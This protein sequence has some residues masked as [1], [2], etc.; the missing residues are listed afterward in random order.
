M[1]TIEPDP[2]ELGSDTTTNPH[3]LDG[4]GGGIPPINT[5]AI[6]FKYASGSR[7]LDG[8]VIKRGIGRGGFGEVYFATSDAGK[9]VALKRIERNLDVELRG[10]SQCL[11]LKH[12]NLIDLYDIRYDDAGDAWV[13]MEYVAGPSL[14]DTIDR[15]PNGLPLDQVQ[16]WF[17][18][19]A[20][21][22]GYLHD[23]GIVHRDLKPANIFQDSSYVKIGDYGLSKFISVSRRS[24]QTESVGTVHYMAPEIGKGVYGKEIDLYALG[25]VLFEM[26]TG[27]TPFDGESSQEI[28]MKHLTADPDLSAVPQPYRFVIERA[29]QK[30]AANRFHSA[31]E[32]VAALAG[33]GS[34][35]DSRERP[36]WRSAAHPVGAGHLY[37]SPSPEPLAPSPPLSDEP[38]ARAVRDMFANIHQWWM[39]GP[40]NTPLKVALLL[41][42]AIL[43]LFSSKLILP[44]AI[45]L[46]SMYI[47]YLGIRLLV[48]SAGRNT[49]AATVPPMPVR[50]PPMPATSQP[51][52]AQPVYAQ[53]VP[54]SPGW[55]PLSWEQQGRQFLCQKSPAEHAA[56][57]S[58]SMLFAA[59]VAG[60]LTIVM[61]AIG[62]ESLV[63][64]ADWRVGPAWFW[65]MTTL[66]TWLVLVAGKQCERGQGELIKR[67][68]GMLVLGLAFGAVAFVSSEFLLVDLGEDAKINRVPQ[69]V[70][71]M[72]DSTG[73]QRLSAFV[74]YFGAVFMSIGWWKLCDPLRSSRL[75]IA[76]ILLSI[77][78]AWIWQLLP[79]FSFPQPWGFMLVAC[80]AI[81][82]Q[83]AA[84][85][86]SP[87][88]RMALCRSRPPGGT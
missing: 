55:H 6:R 47:T 48:Q 32:M 23:H 75:R 57:L 1:A 58:G 69:V 41:G 26:L 34:P 83:L 29:L 81:A 82:T 21:G 72:L 76:P 38:I 18:G 51:V 84:P 42:A 86:L 80:I 39:T 79:F 61:T 74:A 35:I 27:R 15:N 37:A 33:A 88:Q 30:D 53:A 31:A 65:L 25:I 77:L 64:S 11:N 43:A 45:V 16:F 14:K 68:F 85:W 3:E 28:I 20:A 60:V 10:V 17:H 7:P 50:I 59:F 19:I 49:P 56:E 36:P 9:E 4:N 13:V 8:F 62:G 5:A 71:E 22:V 78:A 12:P 40:M 66:G 52:Y 46:G 54:R 63:R 2:K 24:G 44:A 73:G 67:R 70:A 87:E